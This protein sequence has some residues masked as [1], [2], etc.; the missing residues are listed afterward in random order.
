MICVFLEEFV[1]GR[2][3][4]RMI[5][6]WQLKNNLEVADRFGKIGDKC[7]FMSSFFDKTGNLINLSHKQ[8]L[9]QHQLCFPYPN[10]TPFSSKTRW[11]FGHSYKHLI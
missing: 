10:E 7:V 4:G 1:F 5:K 9:N 3:F 11:L 2:I 6:I 8:N